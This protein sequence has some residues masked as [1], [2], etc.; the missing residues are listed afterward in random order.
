M[1]YRFLVCELK[2]GRV[3]DSAPFTIEGELSRVL[4]GHGSGTLSLP[5]LHPECPPNWDQLILPWRNLILVLDGEDRIV[6]HGVP[7]DDAADSVDTV[8]FPC[9]TLEAYFLRRY[10]PSLAY[11]QRD[12]ADIARDLA[13][14]CGDAAG[15]PLNYDCPKTG[16]L[17]DRVYA[18]DEN[19]RVY[20][21]LQELAAVENGFNWTVDVDW[22]DDS[23]TRVKYTFRTGYPH[24]GYRT[25]APEHV[26]DMPGNVSGFDSSRPWGDGDAATHVR[27]IGDGDAESKLMSAPVVDTVREAAGFVRL[28]DRRQFSGVKDV[29]T[30]NGHAQAMAAQLFGGQNV[31]TVTVRDGVGTSL[32]DLTLG[33]TAR[34][35][36]DALTRKLDEVLVVV[37][38]SLSSGSSEFKP[39]LARLGVV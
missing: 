34:V 12:Q 31:L 26:F 17:R 7:N 29:R 36:V 27:A 3:L 30:I 39:T 23:H 1:T 4:Q 16:V 35:T 8:S 15:I 9:V 19:A 2:T 33:D 6:W 11:V 21:R 28:E 5:V 32:G 22:T 14:I 13:S 24:L 25:D 18:D 10:V 38:W 20:N 37:G